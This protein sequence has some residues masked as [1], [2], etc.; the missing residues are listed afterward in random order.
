MDYLSGC[1]GLRHGSRRWLRRRRATEDLAH[2][3]DALNGIASE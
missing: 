2:V 1:R 3:L